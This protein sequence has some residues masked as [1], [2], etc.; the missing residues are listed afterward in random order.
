MRA[1]DTDPAPDAPSP[2]GL[3]T[4]KNYVAEK[5]CQEEARVPDRV[6]PGPTAPKSKIAKRASPTTTREGRSHAEGE[7]TLRLPSPSWLSSLALVLPGSSAG[8]RRADQA[9]PVEAPIAPKEL[10]LNR[11]VVRCSNP[12]ASPSPSDALQIEK[13]PPAGQADRA[14]HDPHGTQ[15]ERQ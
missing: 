9:A 13:A 8:S 10:T 4:A 2:C 6:P 14:S 15:C 7:W 5:R 3:G 12:V 11:V 1:P